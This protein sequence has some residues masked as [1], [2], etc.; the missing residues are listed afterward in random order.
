MNIAHI[1]RQFSPGV[2]GLENY[3]YN[4]CREQVRAGHTVR[5]ITLNRIFDDSRT[6][7]PARET[8]DGIDV[9]RIPYFG[10]R[11]YPLAF[12]VLRHIRTSDLVHVHAMDFFADFLALTRPWHRKPLVLTTHGGFFHTG[13]A[14]RFKKLYF[15][16]VSRLSLGRYGAVIA[17]SHSDR[18]LFE[19]VCD[20]KLTLVENGVDIDK[21]A[22]SARAD[23]HTIIYFGRLA[24][25]KGLERLIQWF[26][27]LLLIDPRWRLII[28]G[29]PM[30]VAIEQLKAVAHN[31]RVGDAVE[32]HDSPSDTDLSALIARSSVFASASRYEGFG[33]ALIEAV[34][35]G[36][37]PAVSDI[38]AHRRSCEQLRLGTLLDHRDGQSPLRLLREFRTAR[39][40]GTVRQAHPRLQHYGWRHVSERIGQVYNQ[41]LGEKER[42]IGGVRIAV[43]SREAA[44]LRVSGHIAR[45][46]PVMI[47]FCNAHTAN[48]ARHDERLAEALDKALV[49]NDGIG[50]DIASRLIYRTAFPDN[51]NGTDFVP[52]LLSK[53]EKPIKLFLVGSAPGVAARAARLFEQRYPQICVTDTQ[54]GFFDPQEEAALAQRIVAADPDLVLVGMGNPRQ[55]IWAAQWMPV[56]QRPIL[57]VGALFDF[58]SGVVRRAPPWVRRLRLEWGYRLMQE[59]SR[60]AERY[61]LGNGRFM[62]RAMIDAWKGPLISLRAPG[63]LPEPAPAADAA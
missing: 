36:L 59:P 17:C 21:F 42:H 26:A 23:A 16:Y 56:L 19:P 57:C 11:R 13:F 54:H 33:L 8:L 30:G 53:Q 51:L 45:R 41:I 9:I 6:A 31:E 38:P 22:N 52:L 47:G 34:A 40:T 32:F 29:K 62:G 7:L 58:T 18:D 35:A 55:E 14:S 44:R 25:N 4:L 28:A 46:D 61:L 12:S 10:S 27:R 50:V 60:L 49:L 2:G 24:P 37:Y 20:H 15:R 1:C 5:M 63:P 43:L 39:D 48:L 3:T